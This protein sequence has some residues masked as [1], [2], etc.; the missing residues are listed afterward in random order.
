[1]RWI[2]N[3]II[4]HVMSQQKYYLS[5]TTYSKQ[6]PTRKHLAHNNILPRSPPS[7][8]CHV[9]SNLRTF[10]HNSQS[11]LYYS[12][13]LNGKINAGKLKGRQQGEGWR[14]RERD[15]ISWSFKCRN[16][17]S[18]TRGAMWRSL[19]FRRRPIFRIHRNLIRQ[20]VCLINAFL[21]NSATI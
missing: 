11:P 3:P 6:P 5:R 14:S 18:N 17:P 16:F 2:I 15:A 12:A 9:M 4:H 13:C 1:M 8:P 7:H 20:S 10:S 21:P 19:E